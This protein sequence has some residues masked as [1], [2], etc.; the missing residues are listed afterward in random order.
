M[1]EHRKH[2]G[3]VALMSRVSAA[4]SM[5]EEFFRCTVNFAC[6]LEA[7]RRPGEQKLSRK[8]LMPVLR[9]NSSNSVNYKSDI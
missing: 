8:S 6:G 2:Q 5:E 3:I 9:T 1:E 7:G 4:D